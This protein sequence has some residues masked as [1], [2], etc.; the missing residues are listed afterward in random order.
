MFVSMV[1]AALNDG[2]STNDD[3]FHRA[4]VDALSFGV[5]IGTVTIEFQVHSR[6]DIYF[7]IFL[8]IYLFS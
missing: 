1:Q 2:A 6:N 7:Y 3:T 5:L 4:C 8:Y